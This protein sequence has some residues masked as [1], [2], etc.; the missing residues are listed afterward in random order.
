MQSQPGLISQHMVT[1]NTA[2]VTMSAGVASALT[3]V[4]EYQIQPG[5]KVIID[6]DA[7]IMLFDRTATVIPDQAAVQ[8]VL[9]D[10][11]K[12][13]TFIVEDTFYRNVKANADTRIQHHP[14][15]GSHR[16]ILQPFSFFQVWI[17]S[18]AAAIGATSLDFVLEAKEQ[19]ISS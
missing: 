12:K 3:K 19:P 8:V 14:I 17:N 4:A 10:A 13:S 11:R 15:R 16:Y 9:V 2:G 5:H 6:R 1:Q 7:V 18:T